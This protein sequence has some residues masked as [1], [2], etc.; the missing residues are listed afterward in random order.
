[1]SNVKWGKNWKTVYASK[2][3]LDEALKL[4]NVIM[5][6]CWLGTVEEKGQDYA[7]QW[8]WKYDAELRSWGEEGEYVEISSE[9]AESRRI[10]WNASVNVSD[11][12]I[13]RRRCGIS[14]EWN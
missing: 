2:S 9:E 11:E 12:E 4:P 14:E 6:G 3:L 7:I 1:M 5:F 10:E 13:E 8:A